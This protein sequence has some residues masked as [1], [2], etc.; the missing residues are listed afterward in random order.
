MLRNKTLVVSVAA[1]TL[2]AMPSA[3]GVAGAAGA[4]GSGSSPEGAAG[5]KTIP[6][7]YIVVLEGAPGTAAAAASADARSR[8]RALG[9]RPDRVYNHALNGFAA[10]L[11][12]SQLSTMRKDPDVAYVVPD[13]RVWAVGTQTPSTW[14]LD[15]VDQRQLPLNNTYSWNYT[16]AGVTAYVIDTGIRA[17][18]TQFGG[19]VGSG[20]TAINDGRGSS[21]CNG[22]GTHVAGTIGGS[23]YGAAKDVRLVPVRVLDCNGSGSTSGVIAGVDWVTAVHS[24]PS[25]ANMSLG[26]GANAALD[27]AVDNSINSGVVYTVA[28]GNSNTNACTASPARTP[29]AI[30]VGATASSDSR[31]SYSNFGT[32]LDLFAPGSSITSAWYTSNTATRTISGTSMAAPHAAGVAALRLQADPTATPSAVSSWITS[33]ATAGVVGNAG[34]GSPNRLLYSVG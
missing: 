22:H 16:G 33:N 9:V 1:A 15:R 12:S 27:A 34:L 5:A 29:A 31:A 17:S 19:R 32:C 20:A 28:A 30:T 18:H 21:D 25:V 2:I 14:G 11:T 4:S 10:K 24:G 26:G 8:A 23:S 3:L 6:G 7:R 13:K